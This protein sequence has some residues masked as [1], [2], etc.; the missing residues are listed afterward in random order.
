MTTV[1]PVGAQFDLSSLGRA[2]YA[3]RRQGIAIL[4]FSVVVGVGISFVL[5]VRYEAST[6]LS[7]A[8][9]SS[10][11]LPLGGTLATLGGQLGI[12]LSGATGRTLLRFYPDLL[13]SYW[14]LSR[15]ATTT[16]QGDTALFDVLLGAPPNQSGS[17][18]LADMDR[19]VALLRQSMQVDVNDRSNVF[20]V[21][22]RLPTRSLALAA[23]ERLIALVT[24]FDTRVRRSRASENRRFLETRT[25]S[26]EVMLGAAEDELARFEQ[27]NRAYA[28]SPDLSLQHERLQRRETL[29]QDVYLSLARSL[30]QA[31]IDEVKE[32]PVLTIVDP[33]HVR[34][35]KVEPRRVQVVAA[36]LAFGALAVLALGFLPTTWRELLESLKR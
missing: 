36:A 3:R 1:Q 6:T 9:A 19:A 22:V 12:D 7:P 33:P 11:R 24:E 26:A 18:T 34:W 8:P 21:S 29:L 32:T 31:R 35:R 17:P 13:G 16:K 4:A 28:Q 25:D 20:R 15:L 23:A 10:D 5:P 14:L 30:E 27:R 2:I